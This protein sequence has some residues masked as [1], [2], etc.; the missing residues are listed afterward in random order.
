[1][2]KRKTVTLTAVGA[3]VALG[4][5]VATAGTLSVPGLAPAGSPRAGDVPVLPARDVPVLTD[6]QV[7]AMP[8]EAQGLYLAPLRVATAALGDYGRTAGATLFGSV[9]LDANNAT[10]DLYLTD[11]G[12][13]PTFEQAATTA[14][15]QPDSVDL[16]LVRVH[17]A[18]VS[19]TA[20]DTAIT[21]FLAR[22]HN[23]PVYAASANPDASGITVEV[24]D[25]AAAR[26]AEAAQ[27]APSGPAI[28][29]VAGSPRVAK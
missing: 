8:T 2:G 29:F 21:G 16:S 9:G 28:A 19:R 27:R 22:P 25:P 18:A 1:M 15:A 3:A 24:P 5:A 17:R 11:P 26:A 23:Y 13:A 12:Q 6:A 20:L 10:V 14:A 4:A 7:A